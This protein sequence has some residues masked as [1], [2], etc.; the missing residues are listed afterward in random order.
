[1]ESAVLENA[2]SAILARIIAAGGPVLSAAVA[3]EI[4]NWSFNQY[5]RDRMSMLADK[6]RTGGAH[7]ARSR[8]A[9]CIRTGQQFFGSG[10]VK[11]APIPAAKLG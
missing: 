4:L 1:M 11:S 10:K 8:R 3:R 5:D 2:E 9:G 6:A 7:T